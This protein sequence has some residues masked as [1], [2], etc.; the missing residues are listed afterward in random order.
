MVAVVGCW[1]DVLPSGFLVLRGTMWTVGIKMVSPL[2]KKKTQ[3]LT[4]ACAF[5]GGS[6]VP[7]NTTQEFWLTKAS[8][9]PL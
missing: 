2:Y 7:K 8:P 4:S 1:V 5:L 9:I 3:K 6:P